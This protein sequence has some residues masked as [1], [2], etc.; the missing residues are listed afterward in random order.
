MPKGN[1]G[2]TID[3]SGNLGGAPNT[4]YATTYSYYTAAQSA[5]PACTGG[6]SADQAQLLSQVSQY[7]TTTTYV[8]DSFGRTRATT[9]GSGT[10]CR[11]YDAESRVTSEQA[12]GDVQATTY[13]YEPAGAR[14]TATNATG[15]VTIGYD[16]AGRTKKNIDSY[17]A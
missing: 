15:T 1:D 8:Y 10:T 7:L 2:R 13:T 17:G 12:P 9:R 3:S 4:R 5:T 14:L 11:S 16:E 6:T